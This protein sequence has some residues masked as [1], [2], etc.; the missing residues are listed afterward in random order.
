MLKTNVIILRIS[1]VFL[2]EFLQKHSAVCKHSIFRLDTH[3]S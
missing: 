3:V 1:R 2:M